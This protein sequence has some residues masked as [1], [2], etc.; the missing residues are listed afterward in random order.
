MIYFIVGGKFCKIGFSKD[1]N[2]R[3]KELQTAC[4]YKL[5][6]VATMPG[7]FATELALHSVFSDQRTHGEWFHFTGNL[8]R[9]VRALVDVS[10]PHYPVTTIKQLLLAS[11]HL[12]VRQASNRQ[13]ATSGLNRRLRRL[14]EAGEAI[15]LTRKQQNK[16]LAATKQQVTINEYMQVVET[17]PEDS[18]R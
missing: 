6:V 3:L 15:S 9:A 16:M 11:Q 13:S 8:K 7:C 14:Y 5:K 4:P 2:T 18:D 12:S 17:L 10:G 1:P